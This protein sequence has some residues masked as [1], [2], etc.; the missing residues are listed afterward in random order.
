MSANTMSKEDLT[1]YALETAARKLGNRQKLAD[2]LEW[3]RPSI[4]FAHKAGRVP[5][6]IAVKLNRIVPEMKPEKT[7]PKIF[8]KRM[9]D[10]E[11][12]HWERK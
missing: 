4:N 10:A 6:G 7:H 5:P 11:R 8:S 3:P 1:R 12:A 2:L 9:M